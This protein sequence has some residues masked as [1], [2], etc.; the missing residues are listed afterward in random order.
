MRSSRFIA[1]TCAP[2]SLFGSDASVDGPAHYRRQPPNVEGAETY[3][4]G[5]LA[6]VRALGPE[7][8]RTV[9]AG[10]TR[11]LFRLDEPAGQSKR[12]QSKP[13]QSNEA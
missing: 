13:D 4:D 12:D 1:S 11:R 2:T 7:T 9:L 10:T 6:L 8:A 3:N 5:L